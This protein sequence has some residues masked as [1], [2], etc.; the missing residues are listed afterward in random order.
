MVESAALHRDGV[1]FLRSSGAHEGKCRS[2]GVRGPSSFHRQRWT[3]EVYPMEHGA[4]G[5]QFGP[6]GLLIV[7]CLPTIRQTA[8]ER[9]RAEITR[10]DRDERDEEDEVKRNLERIWGN[11]GNR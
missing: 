6:I 7:A 8:E 10:A 9:R 11:P 1:L 5:T 2:S 4:R 3:L